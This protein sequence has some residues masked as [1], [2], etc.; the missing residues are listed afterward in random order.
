MHTAYLGP[1]H[2]S[3]VGQNH[4]RTVYVWY[5][6]Q[7]NHWEKNMHGANI[8]GANMQSY[9][10]MPCYALAMNFSGGRDGLKTP[11]P[12]RLNLPYAFVTAGPL[13]LIAMCG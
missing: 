4:V 8:H 1:E 12:H 5:F 7:G 2:I 13:W 9:S 3:R 11:C 10:K 6:W